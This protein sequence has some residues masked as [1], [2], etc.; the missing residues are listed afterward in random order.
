LWIPVLAVL[1]ALLAAL[2]GLLSALLTA[3]PWILCLLTGLA[4]A[5][6]LLTALPWILRLLTGLLPAALLG[7]LVLTHYGYSME[8][9]PIINVLASARFRT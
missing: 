2:P 3:L 1:T 8:F 4:L 7:F 6:T 9:A 5:A